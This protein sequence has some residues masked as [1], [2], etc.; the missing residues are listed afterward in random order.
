MTVGVVIV[1]HYR[2]GE[3]LLQALAPDRARRA[4]LRRGRDRAEAARRRD[5]R[6]IAAAIDAADQGPG[7]LILT[8]MFGGTPSNMRSP[9]SASAGSRS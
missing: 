8:D 2:L 3:E 7:V 4:A 1:A 6:G 5:A 9:S